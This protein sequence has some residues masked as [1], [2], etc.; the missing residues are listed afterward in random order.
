M[1]TG[2]NVDV[3]TGY[4]QN[5]SVKFHDS[6][7]IADQIFPRIDMPAPK[8]KILKYSR[9]SQ[10][11]TSAQQ[12]D[13][14]TEIATSKIKTEFVEPLTV[15]YASSDA[16][17]REDLRDAGIKGN[18]SPPRDLVQDSLEKNA[19]DLD[20]A[21][22]KRVAAAIHAGTWA[23]GNA[24]GVD[25]AGAW[26]TPATS[27]FLV[28]FDVAINK[29]KSNGVDPRSLRLEMDFGTLQALK[30]TDDMREQLKYTSA[31]SLTAD[32][33]AGILQIGQVVIGGVIENI[34]GQ[35]KGSDT[36][37]SKFVWEQN[38]SKGGAFLYAFPKRATKKSLMVGVQARSKL[39]NM[40]FRI[41]EQYWDN[42]LKA[43]YYDSMEEQ[44]EL[45]TALPAG[46][47]WKDTILT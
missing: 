13:P 22:E 3:L 27:T 9:G 11:Q 10:Y 39:D 42:K 34:D 41:T 35:A 18:Q 5:V 23:D 17:T 30:R 25:V 43:W 36:F 7:M 33:L 29:L 32:M 15:Q 28:D 44:D 6:L 12:R 38:A 8:M 14:G 47:L 45:I 19:H 1:P 2:Q 21:S 24:G 20:L 31:K 46:Y 16:I 26:L 37:T 40:N 4:L